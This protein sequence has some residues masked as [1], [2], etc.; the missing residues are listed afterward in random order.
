M[1]LPPYASSGHQKLSS[2]I[3]VAAGSRWRDVAGVRTRLEDRLVDLHNRV[4][5]GAY[6]AQPSRRVYIPKADGRQRPLGIAALVVI[7]VAFIGYLVAGLAGATAA[8]SCPST[9]LLCYWHPPTKAGRK[10]LS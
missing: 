1:R 9:L 8:Y 10:T 2:T 5:G 3:K 7:T 4:H 6:R